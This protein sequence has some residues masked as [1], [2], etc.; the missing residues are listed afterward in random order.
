ML[1]DSVLAF[2]VKWVW[3]L[4]KWNF[5]ASLRNCINKYTY[6]L[7]SSHVCRCIPFRYRYSEENDGK[8]PE[9]NVEVLMITSTSGPG[10]LFPKVCIRG[11]IYDFNVN[12]NCRK[13]FN[14]HNISC[15]RLNNVVPPPSQPFRKDWI[16]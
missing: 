16:N 6:G 1:Y 4:F 5:R 7:N 14:Y 13:S 8:K 9:E 11:I 12:R 15:L 2:Y 3:S 10:L